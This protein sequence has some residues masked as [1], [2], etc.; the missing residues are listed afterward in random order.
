LVATILA[1][2][3]FALASAG[4]V[5]ADVASADFG[6]ADFGSAGFGGIVSASRGAVPRTQSITRRYGL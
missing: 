3:G 4:F 1:S 2:L 6:S 5:S